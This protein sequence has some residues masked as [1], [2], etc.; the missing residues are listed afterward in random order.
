MNIELYELFY[1][2]LHSYQGVLVAGGE[3]VDSKGK[4]TAELYFPFLN[5]SCHIPD[6]PSRRFSHGQAGNVLCGG[7]GIIN[8]WDY[9]TSCVREVQGEIIGINQNRIHSPTLSVT[10]EGKVSINLQKQIHKLIH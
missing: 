3:T 1:E 5:K 10:K 8:T 2:L 4:D 9:F 6:M 7:L